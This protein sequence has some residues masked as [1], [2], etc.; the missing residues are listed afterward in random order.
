VPTMFLVDKSG[1]VVSRS[2]SV[3]EVKEKLPELL[4]GR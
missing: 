3:A 4:K 2:S 1:T